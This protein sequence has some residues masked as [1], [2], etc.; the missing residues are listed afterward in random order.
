MNVFCASSPTKQ[1]QN[2]TWSNN[3][4]MKTFCLLTDH[5]EKKPIVDNRFCPC[6]TTHDK[7]LLLCDVQ[8]NFTG[9]WFSAFML[10]A[11]D[12]C[13]GLPIMHHTIGHHYQYVKTWRQQQKSPHKL[14]QHH[15]WIEPQEATCIE[16]L[17]KFGLWFLSY[18]SRDTKIQ[19]NVLIKILYTIPGAE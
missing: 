1:L 10:I 19:T 2:I 4:Q 17:V 11:F 9:I 14:S 6:C 15:R 3:A 13:L 8:H 5:R 12:R 7:Y 16:Y 18:A